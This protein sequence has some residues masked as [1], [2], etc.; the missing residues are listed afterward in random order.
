MNEKAPFDKRVGLLLLLLT[1]VCSQFVIADTPPSDALVK[2]LLTVTQPQKL[3]DQ[4]MAQMDGVMQNSML[5]AMPDQKLTPEQ[6][7]IMAEMRSK[8]VALIRESMSWEIMEP[9]YI[10][11]YQKSFTQQEVEGIL[12]FYR[13]DAGQAVIA[14]MPQVMQGTTQLTQTVLSTMMPKIQLL[15]RQSVEKL[16]ASRVSPSDARTAVPIDES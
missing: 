15:V 5:Q 16:K 7:S 12:V 8:M 9:L 11:I 14:K 10:D 6:D 2:E 3:L 1:S 13:S 4:V